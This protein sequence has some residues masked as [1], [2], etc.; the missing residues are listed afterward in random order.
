MAKRCVGCSAVPNEVVSS[1]VSL[2]VGAPA[3]CL[4]AWA[5][6]GHYKYRIIFDNIS[7]INPMS[8]NFLIIVLAWQRLAGL[9]RDSLT[10]VHKY[11]AHGFC[12]AL[13][14]KP[15]LLARHQWP[16]LS[17]PRNGHLALRLSS[18]WLR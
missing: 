6:V 1:V 4:N 15:S 17:P 8:S 9:Y 3:S 18:S 11:S 14:L 12:L 2:V 13:T 16:V 7:I 10:V 5:G